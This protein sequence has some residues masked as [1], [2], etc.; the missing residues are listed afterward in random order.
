[1]DNFE[2]YACGS[3]ICRIVY[4]EIVQKIQQDEILDVHA[5]SEYGENRIL[6]KCAQVFRREPRKGVA[7]PVSI[8]LNDCVGNYVH[9]PNNDEYNHI[10]M[11]DVVKIELGVNIGNCISILGDTFLYKNE[12]PN[13]LSKIKLLDDLSRD[14]SELIFPTQT[15]D[16]LRIHIE[17]KCT[18]H[19]CFPMQ[20]CISFQQLDGHLSTDDSKYIIL[21]HRK[22]FDIN[23]YMTSLDNL[24]FEFEQDEVY[25]INLTI[26]EED[27]VT[28]RTRHGPHIYRFNENHYNLKLKSSK[29]FLSRVKSI[30]YNNAFVS[31]KYNKTPAD[32]M[33]MRECSQNMILSSFPIAYTGKQPIF[34]KKFTLIVTK[35]KCVIP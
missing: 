8:S 17:S 10:K 33:G 25:T 15:N 23:D 3:N 24:C 34:H 4:D 6:Q 21:N 35:D 27:D 2:K 28:F 31:S 13:L 5:L 16:E 32:R 12:C 11:G 18:E 19:D 22:T 29:A 1:M 20:N 26:H 7:F 14:I 30:H 9:E